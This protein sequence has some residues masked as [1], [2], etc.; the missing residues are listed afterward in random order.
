MN[1]NIAPNNHEDTIQV[2]IEF[3]NPKHIKDK[4][5]QVMYKNG[6]MNLSVASN[7]INVQPRFEVSDPIVIAQNIKRRDDKLGVSDKVDNTNQSQN[8][9]LS[10]GPVQDKQIEPHV[11]KSN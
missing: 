3:T 2:A 1:D 11:V 6:G 9:S 8:I 7:L 4:K 10:Q 5:S